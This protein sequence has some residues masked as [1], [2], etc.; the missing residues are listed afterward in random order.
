MGRA[1]VEPDALGDTMRTWPGDSTNIS[2]VIHQSSDVTHK[3]GD[4]EAA[5]YVFSAGQEKQQHRSKPMAARVLE[6][7]QRTSY[8]SEKQSDG[9]IITIPCFVYTVI[10]RR[11]KPVRRTLPSNRCVQHNGSKN[12]QVDALYTL[13]GSI[14]PDLYSDEYEFDSN[15]YQRLHAL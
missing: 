12:P 3:S 6:G 1:Q 7:K 10:A 15:E 11:A 8:R 5:P 13:D 4:K 2:T 9:S 14:I